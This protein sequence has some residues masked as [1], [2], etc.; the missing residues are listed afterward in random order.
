MTSTS[1]KKQ[2]DEYFPLL[3][4]KQQTLVL[5]MVKNFLNIDTDVKRITRKQYNQE[6]DEAVNRVEDGN[7]VTQ[8]ETT[9]ELSKF[10]PMSINNFHEMIDQA[11]LDQDA[12]RIISHKDLKNKA[13][14]WK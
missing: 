9:K 12:G 11:K 1:I 5:E 4:S 14:T 7:I 2:F 3:S 6:I 8:D 10:E 13:K